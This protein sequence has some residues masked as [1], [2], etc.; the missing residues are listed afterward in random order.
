MSELFGRL[1]WAALKHDP[2][3][4]TADAFMVFA[5]LALAGFL[6]YTKKWKW[7]WREY[8]TSLD[9]KRIG[10]MYMVVVIL[11]VF[12]GLVDAFMM[13]A[14]QAYAVGPSQG[15]L[16]AEHFQ[17]IFTAHGTTMIFFVGM[18]VVFG[19]INLI[20]PLQIGA[21]D[22]AFPFLNAVSFWL[23]AAAAAL[24]NFSLIVGRFGDAGWL[25]YPPLSGLDYNPGVGI[26][27][28]V[29]TVQLAGVG[30][31]LTGVNFLVTIFKM[32]CPGMT[33]MRMPLFT[34]C[35]MA[36]LILVVF[37]FP[38]LAGTLFMLAWDRLLDMH[39]FTAGGGG[40]FMLYTNLIW[41]WGHPEVYILIF[42]A[43]GIFSEVVATFSRKR[44]YGY[45]SMVWAIVVITFL[46]FIVWLHHFFVMG[47]GPLVNGFFGVST[48]AIAIPTGVKVFNWVFTKLRGRVSMATPMLWF[49]GFVIAFTV[50]GLAGILLAVPPVDFQVHNSLFVI[51]HF[52]SV[53][54]GG[55]LFG[56][57]AG[58]SYWFPKF[59]GFQLNEKIGHYAF[60][61]WFCGFLIAFMPLYLLGLMG[62][63]RRLNH[64]DVP[65]WQPL[66][67]V[68]GVG[69]IL[70]WCGALLQVLQVLTSV[71]QRRQLRDTTGD[72]WNGRTL[73]WSTP[74][75][76]PHYNFAIIPTVHSR[77]AFWEMKQH[78]ETIEKRPYEG[79]F[80][81]KKTAIP[82]LIGGC[83]FVVCFAIVWHI[84]W[85]AA[86]SLGGI[87]ICM[88]VRFAHKETDEYFSPER[89]EE[90]ENARRSN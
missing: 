45:V 71:K 52:H 7:L 89:V 11:M 34:W 39:F 21:R 47:A 19:M 86:A 27:Y 82:I 56:F 41:A 75:P 80:M 17:E 57:L 46:S 60:W 23:F 8:L 79:F 85:L 51:A 70:V 64:Y 87:V 61:C 2:I 3:E 4:Y 77:D 9:P 68:A 22:I 72:P 30:S 29:W 5:L 40:N 76:P 50:G 14:Q 16:T 59:M 66:F 63:T 43:F 90:I 74:S 83:G 88:V 49:M 38:I 10:T 81:P 67:L 32:R 48:M 55:V 15:Y 31:L 54:I 37:A 84:V 78:P 58:F 25:S 28:W 73:E 26:D 69:V 62:T 13:R 65:D 12:K 1:T 24:I 42:P 44:I 36:T 53:I 33:M 20:V 18:G 35:A 6:F